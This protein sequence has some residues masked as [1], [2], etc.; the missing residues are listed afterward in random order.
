MRVRHKFSQGANPVS[1]K[2]NSQG[3]RLEV[4][5]LEDLDEG[6]TQVQGAELEVG[7]LE[8]P[9]EVRTQVQGA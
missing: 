9:D 4:E 3:A 2:P 6:R 5:T 7:T 1:G 8:D